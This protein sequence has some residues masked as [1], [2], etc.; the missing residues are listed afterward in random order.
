MHPWSHILPLVVVLL[1]RCYAGW[2]HNRGVPRGEGRGHMRGLPGAGRGV[3]AGG[4][5]QRHTEER[6]TQQGRTEGRGR[7]QIPEAYGGEG[8]GGKPGSY[9]GKGD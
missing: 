3:G 7:G 1:Q 6:G 5:Y 9:L 4:T 8:A 2:A